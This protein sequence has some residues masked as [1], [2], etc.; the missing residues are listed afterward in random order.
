MAGIRMT[1]MSLLVGPTKCEEVRSLALCKALLAQGTLNPL[2]LTFSKMNI[3]L[4]Q[5]ACGLFPQTL[6][7]ILPSTGQNK[8]YG[9]IL[10]Y[11]TSVISV[12]VSHFVCKHS[13]LVEKNV[14]IAFTLASRWWDGADSLAVYVF[15][16]SL[17]TGQWVTIFHVNLKVDTGSFCRRTISRISLRAV[18][19]LLAFNVLLT[20]MP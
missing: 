19:L 3:F 7:S 18:L 17:S 16:F 5:T 10:L 15:V 4:S 20:T 13:C 8:H 14:P 11:M 6:S 12:M 1:A 9:N 2:L